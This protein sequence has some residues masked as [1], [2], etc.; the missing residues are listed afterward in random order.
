MDTKLKKFNFAMLKKIIALLLCLVS[1][2]GIS[3]QLV[4]TAKDM[5]DTQVDFD[6]Y[7]DAFTYSGKKEDIW[8][9]STFRHT[10]NSYV[11]TLTVMI[12]EYDNGSKEAYKTKVETINSND[13]ATYQLCKENLISL[14]QRKNSF[15]YY[16]YALNNGDIIATG[17]IGEYDGDGD[18]ERINTY[19]VYDN[20]YY[21]EVNLLNFDGDNYGKELEISA[22]M[23]KKMK[24]VGA[25]GVCL[26]S[27]EIQ[28]Y[29]DD[30]TNETI[31]DGYYS[32]KVN[33]EKLKYNLVQGNFLDSFYSQTYDE[34]KEEY[35]GLSENL[36][37]NYSS[38]SY[39]V[40]DAEGNTYTNVKSLSKK[41]TN[42]EIAEYFSSLGFYCYQSNGVLLTK[43]GMAYSSAFNSGLDMVYDDNVTYATT[44]LHRNTM[45]TTSVSVSIAESET[46]IYATTVVTD[47][48]E[49]ETTRHIYAE[50]SFSSPFLNG[51]QSDI[52]CFVG[53]DLYNDSD[54]C[55]FATMY[56][57]IENARIIAKDIVVTCGILL[58]QFLACFI[59]LLTKAGRRDGD[60]KVYLFTT[61]RMFTDWRII[62]D[63][64]LGGLSVWGLLLYID[65]ADVYLN[66][67]PDTAMKIVPVL[68]T[69]AVFAVIDLFLFTARHIRNKSLFKNLFSVWIVRKVYSLCRKLFGKMTVF[70]M[71]DKLLNFLLL[72]L[73]PVN[74][75]GFFL[76]DYE[77]DFILFVLPVLAVYDLAAINL[78]LRAK[79]K[80][81]PLRYLKEYLNEKLRY[82][83]GFEKETIIKGA[84]ILLVNVLGLFF[85]IIEV[86]DNYTFFILLILALFD[87]FVA[88]QLIRFIAGVKKIFSAIDEIKNGNYNVQI[89]LFSL[90]SSLR[91][92]ATRLMSLRDGLKVAVDEAVKQEQTKT[93]LITNVSHD[94]K[95][96]LTSVINYVELLKKC[97][98][99]DEEA[100]EYLDILG[101]KSDRLKK[102]IE[103][104]VEASKA[105]TGNLKTE[106]VDVS[107][108]EI[109]SQI[110]GEYSDL[111]EQKGLSLITSFPQENIIVRA[112]SK[113]LYR[114]LE[115]LMGN[116]SKY[117]MENTRVYLNV[118]R[119]TGK[120]VFSIKNISGSP[121]NI[122]AEQLKSRFVRGDEA[123]TTEG[124]GLGLSIAES[125]CTLQG[126]KLDI[127][128]NGDLFV[129]EV[130]MNIS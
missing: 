57:K 60:E 10:F 123:R 99:G 86:A 102:L 84:I 114:V 2:V 127:M 38:G 81:S 56:D 92:P 108:N 51:K 122:S 95:T 68:V 73:L 34:F 98:I 6:V 129:A 36:K 20:W 44:T 115:N 53:V 66:D 49:E 109:T 82:V 104:L 89:N 124:S 103:D 96:P 128:I 4:S 87:L 14:I 125:L 13:E 93:E 21:D 101:E 97:N 80:K 120:G 61:D 62:L 43:E 47:T 16:L 121:L 113:M 46:G 45:D 74:I 79:F 105:S 65:Y 11:D 9:T 30:G 42:E 119:R 67:V 37:N 88:I 17:K 12:S 55:N 91:E 126:G 94:L 22:E 130:E 85:G 27:C 112:D 106:M 117:A 71:K 24:E 64:A 107:L 50:D 26:A 118:E 7:A 54:T 32:F 76:V 77:W 31:S 78:L 29:D 33:E 28:I 100:K 8:K 3:A 5:H 63:V 69:V 25:D 40:R 83:K 1:A 48:N 70:G 19:E 90:P 18:A 72:F 39:Y 15:I 41:S 75:L 23:K 59:Y 35:D 116:V 110:I 111:L 52:V 58:L